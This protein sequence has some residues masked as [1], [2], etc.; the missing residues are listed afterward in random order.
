MWLVNYPPIANKGSASRGGAAKFQ[1]GNP[2]Y[3]VIKHT[4]RMVNAL[5]ADA[6][7]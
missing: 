1:L 7:G 5:F 2:W 3:T 4:A 6:I